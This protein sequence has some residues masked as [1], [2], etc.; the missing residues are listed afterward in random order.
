MA[1]PQ[2][3]IILPV[4]NEAQHIAQTLQDLLRNHRPY[5]II[6]VDGGSSDD[7]REQ[8]DR[9]MQ[10]AHSDVQWQLLDSAPGRARQM[11]HGA[12]ASHGN[13]L[14]FLHADTR[15]PLD[16]LDRIDRH[17]LAG[18]LW[19]RFAVSLDS[20][21][22]VFRIIEWFMNMRSALTGIATGDQAIF[23]RRDLF[24]L[25]NGYADIP[26]M[27]DIELCRRLKQ[28]QG[29]TLERVTVTTSARR[30]QQR[31]VLCTVLLMW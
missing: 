4:L 5:E 16:A 31:G 15:L 20:D 26:L 23:V 1:T 19:G 22:T 12:Q 25:M 13:V 2:I 24:E 14:L 21:K 10:A 6:L 11:N 3:S 29:P 18:S 27:E 7:T 30:W 28:V 17:M 9:E 8:I